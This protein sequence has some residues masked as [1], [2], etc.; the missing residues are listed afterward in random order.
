MRSPV[1]IVTALLITGLLLSACGTVTASSPLDKW[2]RLAIIG[3]GGDITCPSST[4]CWVTSASNA[5]LHTTDGGH[6][7]KRVWVNTGSP[8]Q[9]ERIDC[10][11][12]LRCV[13]TGAYESGGS[14]STEFLATN[15]GG[16]T[17]FGQDS[18]FTGYAGDVTCVNSTFCYGATLNNWYATTD[19]GQTWWTSQTLSSNVLLG[20]LQC[21]S[22]A[23]CLMVVQTQAPYG[24]A[25]SLWRSTDG[26]RSFKPVAESIPFV[27]EDL[28]CFSVEI[29][30]GRGV[31]DL[32]SEVVESHDGGANWV[33]MKTLPSSPTGPTFTSVRCI[34]LTN[35]LVAATGG[36]LSHPFTYMTH[37]GF[38]TVKKQ[39]LPFGTW[40]INQI[41]CP[42]SSVC[43]AVGQT[44]DLR[45]EVFRFTSAA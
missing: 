43:F 15:D 45:G 6:S 24:N 25:S 4:D 18:Y 23:N 16:K 1:R 12:I 19:G 38:K 27:L 3:G 36:T 28:Q 7:W 9:V 44:A 8:V 22:A 21:T 10:P 32:G 14:Q 33:S 40:L 17:W 41:V 5:V 31:N 2:S 34:S 42:S 37:N 26:A 20:P 11:T 29:C 39:Q 13:G 30:V 35:C